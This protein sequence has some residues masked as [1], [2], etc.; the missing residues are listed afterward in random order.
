MFMNNSER[1]FKGEFEKA[2]HLETYLDDS[3]NRVEVVETEG[4]IVVNGNPN[5]YI[6]KEVVIVAQ[7][8]IEKF[9]NG[10]TKS[11][12]DYSRK[13]SDELL[14]DKAV[15]M[16][17]VERNPSVLM[18]LPPDLTHNKEFMNRAVDVLMEKPYSVETCVVLE[19]VMKNNPLAKDREFVMKAVEADYH[20]IK[21]SPLKDDMAVFIK[22]FAMH[23]VEKGY[24][25]ERIDKL[26]QKAS[27]DLHAE[28][29]VDND[30]WLKRDKL[31]AERMIVIEQKEQLKAMQPKSKGFER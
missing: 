23:E 25:S 17:L 8:D 24:F 1:K 7:S 3:S 5:F 19:D 12:F 27:W 31:I 28:G 16:Q 30:D 22:S 13:V 10:E 18:C 26:H 9:R 15:A 2:S 29:R 20:F 14:E 21:D 6:N 11:G 4:K